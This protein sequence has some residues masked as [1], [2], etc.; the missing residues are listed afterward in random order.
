MIKI[1][2][3]SR[4][5]LRSKRQSLK[6]LTFIVNLVR[7]EDKEPGYEIFE[8]QI[9]RYS[10]DSVEYCLRKVKFL[11]FVPNDSININIFASFSLGTSVFSR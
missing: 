7:V 9:V 3:D 4:H 8:D 2:K 10:I 11:K 6:V 1:D 5:P